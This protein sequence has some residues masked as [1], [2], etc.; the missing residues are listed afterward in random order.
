[1]PLTD[2]QKRVLEYLASEY[3][4]LTERD[5]QI[6]EMVADLGYSDGN[7]KRK[8]KTNLEQERIALLAAR[9]MRDTGLSK[10]A[11]HEQ[12]L[13]DEMRRALDGTIIDR[14]ALG[15][16]LRGRPRGEK[17]EDHLARKIFSLD[18]AI[19]DWEDRVGLPITTNAPDGW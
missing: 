17:P 18:G 3:E 13:K 10:A 9:K 8:S 19:A 14:H 5:W 4:M 12:M 7:E 2:E 6:A 11:V 1:M 15:E 16:Y